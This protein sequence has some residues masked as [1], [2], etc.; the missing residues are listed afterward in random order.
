MRRLLTLC[1]L[2]GLAAGCGND[3]RGPGDAGS[4]TVV[5]A[6]GDSITAGAPLWDPDARVRAQIGPAADPRSQYQYWAERR[7]PGVAFR[8][9]GVA[10]QLTDEIARRLGS[11]AEGADVLIVQGGTNDIAQQRPVKAAARNLRAMVKRGKRL[12]LRVALAEVLPWNRGGARAASAIR[13]LNRLIAGIGADEGVPV[14]PWY[15][16]LEDPNA[17]GTMKAEWTI[18]GAH[19]SVK[20]YR[21]LADVVVLP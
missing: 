5:A 4:P 17:P 21:R 19:P 11:C 9:C 7:L 2:L 10:G 16:R 14:F 6:L 20:G 3:P 15:R 18:D 1:C 13:R 8:N 12:G